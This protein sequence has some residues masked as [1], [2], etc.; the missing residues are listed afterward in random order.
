MREQEMEE[1]GRLIARALASV[2]N[3]SELAAVRADVGKLCQRFPLY[4][5]RLAAYD[6]VLAS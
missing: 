4:A 6:R 3:E 2:D 5:E 1:V